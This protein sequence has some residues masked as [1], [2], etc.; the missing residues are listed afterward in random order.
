[1]AKAVMRS[2]LSVAHPRRTLPSGLVSNFS[3]NSNNGLGTNYQRTAMK[4]A[5]FVFAAAGDHTPRGCT[6]SVNGNLHLIVLDV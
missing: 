5:D 2:V 4:Y 6:L 3:K 1:M